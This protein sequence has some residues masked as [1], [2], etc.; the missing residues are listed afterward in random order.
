[1]H[2]QLRNVAIQLSVLWLLIDCMCG[3]A[4]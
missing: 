1:M 3:T 4:M 2:M